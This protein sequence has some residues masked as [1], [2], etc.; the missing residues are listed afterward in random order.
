MISFQR[1]YKHSTPLFEK[2]FPMEE[3]IQKDIRTVAR[4]LKD[5]AEREVD[6]IEE[7]EALEIGRAYGI[8]LLEVY[9]RALRLGVCPCRYLR[10]REILS[11]QEQ[12][13]LAESHVAVVGAG[14]LGGSVLS[15][16]A[17]IGIGHLV[18]VDHDV[19][20]E[21]NLNRQAFSHAGNLGKPK[22]EEAR[23]ELERINP[24]VVVSV[25][26]ARLDRTNGRDFLARCQVVV[27]ALDNVQS[28]LFL[29][30]AAQDL[31]IP[32]VH[33]ALAGF[34]GQVMSIFPGDGGLRQIYGNMGEENKDQASRP[35]AVL[36]VP[37][38]T[39]AF[40]AALQAMEVV[41]ILLNRGSVFRKAM[42]YVDLERGEINRFTFEPR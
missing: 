1:W 23:S 34:E 16:L 19:F 18:V 6:A 29:E 41:K 13:K 2:E 25:H 38:I 32:L 11:L 17:R 31:G 35:E 22:A 20:E 8:P 30:E 33:G 12:L 26:R 21:T 36:G 28:R 3:S 10:N 15:L 9:T 42:T 40:I 39:P 5:L 4:I 37:A 7:H 14:G 27:D 24:G